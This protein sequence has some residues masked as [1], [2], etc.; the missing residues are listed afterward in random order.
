MSAKHLN[1]LVVQLC[2]SF[3]TVVR[4]NFIT[5][6]ETLLRK[7]RSAFESECPIYG[8][9]KE[10]DRRKLPLIEDVMRACHR[11]RIELKG[12]KNGKDPSWKE[13][14]RNVVDE[15]KEIW[16]AASIPTISTQA[17]QKKSTSITIYVFHSKS[18]LLDIMNLD[19]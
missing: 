11:R 19:S 18:H 16:V 15:V 14:V 13:I 8:I 1:L 12:E 6:L 5:L 7:K 4:A 10:L 2:L 17:M 3:N 9:P